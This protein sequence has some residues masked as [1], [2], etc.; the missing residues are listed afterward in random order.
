MKKKILLNDLLR[1]IRY[2]LTVSAL[3]QFGHIQFRPN[4]NC[5]LCG[6]GKKHTL[7]RFIFSRR[8]IMLFTHVCYFNWCRE[9]SRY[10]SIAHLNGMEQSRNF[11]ECF[12]LIRTA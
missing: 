1:T 10:Y 3:T 9:G 8:K 6:W 11:S 2:N 12:G 5:F 4:F 7:I